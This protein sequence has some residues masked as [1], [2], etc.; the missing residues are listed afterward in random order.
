MQSDLDKFL[1][2]LVHSLLILVRREERESSLL[3]LRFVI[4][5]L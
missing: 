4:E 5:G 3:S 2:R 1:A